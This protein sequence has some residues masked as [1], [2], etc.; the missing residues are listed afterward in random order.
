VEALGGWPSVR[1]L[2]TLTER[3]GGIDD[4]QKLLALLK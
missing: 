2:E 1:A 4:A 3:L